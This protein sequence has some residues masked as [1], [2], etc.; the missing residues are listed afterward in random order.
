MV[1]TDQ[2]P[3]VK[4]ISFTYLFTVRHRRKSNH[5]LEF[6]LL[7]S[8]LKEKLDNTFILSLMF[9]LCLSKSINEVLVV[10]QQSPLKKIMKSLNYLYGFFY[11]PGVVLL[12][13]YNGRLL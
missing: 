8:M 10:N 6:L 3:Y 7:I 2:I 1:W 13:C 5:S 4:G 11:K 9:E 12:P